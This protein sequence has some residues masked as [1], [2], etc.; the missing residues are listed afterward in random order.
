MVRLANALT[1]DAYPESSRDAIDWLKR[2]ASLG[3]APAMVFLGFAYRDGTGVSRDQEEAGRWF[4]KA[5]ENGDLRSMLH[6]GRLF[7]WDSPSPE[8]AL[9]WLR[10]AADAGFTDSYWALATLCA[11]QKSPYYSPAEAVHWYRAIANTASCGAPRAL[12]C[13]AMMTRDGHGTEQN[14]GLARTYLEMALTLPAPKAV[15]FEA[16]RLLSDMNASFL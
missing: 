5:Y 7:A 12:V 16:E 15:L 3:D 14:I 4:T 10:S 1:R 2:A 8:K 9:P 13:L 6:I 11:D